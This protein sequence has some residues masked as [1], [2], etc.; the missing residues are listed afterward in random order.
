M[1]I[2]PKWIKAME[3]HDSK[4]ELIIYMNWLIPRETKKNNT[5]DNLIMK[6]KVA[7]L[8]ASSTQLYPSESHSNISKCLAIWV[9]C[10]LL[11]CFTELVVTL[12]DKKK[13]G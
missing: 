4:R 12:C 10:I 11:K 5:M 8:T 6:P 1:T 9:V 2:L 3:G 7:N 13:Y